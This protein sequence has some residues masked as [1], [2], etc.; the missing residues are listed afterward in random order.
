MS[1]W[2]IF[3]II[4][5]LA[6]LIYGMKVMSEALQKMAGSQLRHILGTMT[7]NRFTGLITGM[8]V[9]ASVQS[10]TAT[11]VMTVS[12]VNAG[13]LTLAQAISV[14]MGANIGTTFTAWIM[15]LGFSF[16]MANVVF[17]VFF[18]ALL[19]IY[20][21]KHRYVGDFL[22]GVAFMFFAISTL[23]A[24]GKEMDLSHNQSVIEFFSSFDKDSYLTIFAF[25]GL[26]TIL[27]FCMQSS[28]AL[29]AITM[30][31]CSSGVLPIYMGIALVLGENIG[32]TITSNI[33]AMGANTQARRAAMAHLSFN[34]FGVLWVLCIFYPFID[35]VCGF[36]GVD[37][38]SGHID[39]SRLSVV[40]AAFH[41]TFNVCNTAVLIWFIPQMEKLVCTI[42]KPNA[43]KDEDDF[44]LRYIGDNTLMATPELSVLEARKEIQ[45]FAERIQ[46]MFSM[47]RELLG[48]KNENDFVKLFT[49]IEKYEGISDNMEI[50]IANYLDKVSDSH[51]SDETKAK[52]RAMLREI[53]EIESI[54]DSCYNIAR[55]LNRKLRGKEDFTEQQYDHLHQMFELTDDSLTQMNVMLSSR[56][57]D[58]DVNRSF[59]IENEIN[60][61][62]TQ[63][64]S[65]NINDV[66]NHLYTY[67]IGTMYMDIVSECEKLADYVIN[68]VEARMG[69]KQREA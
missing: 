26:G 14:I 2:I 25:L 68:V 53:S 56:R 59:N 64:K 11:T 38:H 15:T 33:A 50:E 35:M 12:F 69:T 44:R 40:L 5:S 18:I 45:S 46:R 43:M 24:T 19:L 31:L 23:G 62:R 7:K 27:T 67:A 28:A 37:P 52:I 60:N 47:V 51:L 9:T 58:L 36:V 49:R 41:T 30:V 13:L 4:G 16:N 63:L 65:Q 10:S 22:F 21:K 17:P 34:V 29:M 3:K 54:G 48:V 42:I 55:T 39:A 1:I 57:Y 32:T 8:F 66:N 6:L 20:R 61:Y